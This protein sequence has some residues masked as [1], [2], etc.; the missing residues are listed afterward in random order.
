MADRPL[1]ALMPTGVALV[2]ISRKIATWSKRKSISQTGI[3]QRLRWTR[4]L[5]TNIS[6]APPAKIAAPT[7]SAPAGARATSQMPATTGD[8]TAARCIT[9]RQRGRGRSRD[10]RTEADTPVSSGVPS[11]CGSDRVTTRT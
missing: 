8:G 1:S 7:R 4:L 3:D 10:L 9:P 2:A 11:G 5:A 6:R